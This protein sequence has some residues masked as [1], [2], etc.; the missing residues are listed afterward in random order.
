MVPTYDVYSGDRV[1]YIFSR[2]G[3][4]Q[5]TGQDVGRIQIARSAATERST[6]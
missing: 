3:D 4:R 5:C 1:D 6:S 2:P